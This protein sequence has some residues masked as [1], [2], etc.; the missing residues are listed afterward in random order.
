MSA[1]TNTV[2][3]TNQVGAREDLADVIYRVAAKQERHS[4]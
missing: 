1:P 3:S 4:G 2:T